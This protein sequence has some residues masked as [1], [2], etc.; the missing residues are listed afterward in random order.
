MPERTSLPMN[1][2]LSLM[3]LKLKLL[4]SKVKLL[5]FKKLE[6]LLLFLTSLRELMI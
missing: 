3:V 5:E 4:D 6:M 1:F 2:R